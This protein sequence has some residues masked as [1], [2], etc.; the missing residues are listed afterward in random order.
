MDETKIGSMVEDGEAAR[1]EEGGR[2]EGSGRGECDSAFEGGGNLGASTG[3]PS[4][5]VSETQASPRDSM[6]LWR[7]SRGDVR[8]EAHKC[9]PHPG[10]TA[11]EFDVPQAV[12]SELTAG[13][14]TL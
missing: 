5:G 7:C 6:A 4:S 13:L 12:E 11:A 1:G 3:A 2:G 8:G 10:G 14:Q 9:Q